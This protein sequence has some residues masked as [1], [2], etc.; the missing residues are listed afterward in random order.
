MVIVS[1]RLLYTKGVYP[2]GII[3]DNGKAIKYSM[4]EVPALN[5]IVDGYGV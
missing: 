4:F 2:N 3:E 1:F 5:G